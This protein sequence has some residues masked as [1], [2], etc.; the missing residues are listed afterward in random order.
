MGVPTSATYD[1]VRVAVREAARS[2]WDDLRSVHPSESF[3][4]FGLATTAQLE[5]VSASELVL[6]P[7]SDV[8][9]LVKTWLMMRAETPAEPLARFIEHARR[10]T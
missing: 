3:Y 5:A 4:Y 10:P 1:L 9:K 7:L 8:S 2:A 6:R